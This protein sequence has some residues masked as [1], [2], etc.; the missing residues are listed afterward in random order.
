MGTFLV[1]AAAVAQ[2]DSFVLGDV[3][4]VQAPPPAFF[5]FVEGGIGYQSNA[6]YFMAR[7]GGILHEVF[8]LIFKVRRAGGDPWNGAAAKFWDAEVDIV[9]F[10]M[11][12]V[13]GRYGE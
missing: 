12:L 13:R 3:F 7:Y 10:D 8:Y 4:I 9:G 6:L 11:C 1:P 5:N 2:D